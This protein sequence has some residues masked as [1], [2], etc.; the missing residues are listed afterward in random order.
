MAGF[1]SRNELL[2]RLLAESF[3]QGYQAG[4]SGPALRGLGA[5]AE[6][7]RPSDHWWL[8][9]EGALSLGRSS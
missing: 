3:Q 6:R 7:R 9:G 4:P 8:R 1:V 2:D 5:G